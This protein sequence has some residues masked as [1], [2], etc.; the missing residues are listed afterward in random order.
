MA[1]LK[2]LQSRVQ[3]TLELTGDNFE[4]AM[5]THRLTGAG[6]LLRPGC[7]ALTY[8][9]NCKCSSNVLPYH[10]P[11]QKATITLKFYLIPS[12]TSTGS[13]L[14]RSEADTRCHDVARYKQRSTRPRSRPP[15]TCTRSALLRIS[16]HLASWGADQHFPA[17]RFA[18]ARVSARVRCRARWI[19][20]VIEARSF[21]REAEG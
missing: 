17:C 4:S 6:Q 18:V 2:S 15:K 16:V 12:L 5:L 21:K 19:M 7:Q 3:R 9:H 8:L 13:T 10:M 20:P 11:S 14:K 1:E